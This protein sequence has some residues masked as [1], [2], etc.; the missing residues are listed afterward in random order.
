MSES[1]PDPSK[2]AKVR[3][4][5]E[6]ESRITAALA[7]VF[8]NIPRENFVQQRWFKAR[9]GHDPHNVDTAALWEKS[10]RADIIIFYQDRAL[11]VLELKREDLE[12]TQDDYEQAQSYA[13]QLTP[14]PPL[15]IVSNGRQTRVYDSNTGKEWSDDG[16]A[17]GSISRLVANAAKLAAS[18]MRWTIEALMGRELGVWDKAIRKTTERHIAALTNDRGAS[19]KPFAKHLLFPRIATVGLLQ[20]LKDG[21]R[22]VVVHGDPLTGKSNVLRELAT[23]TRGSDEFAVLL[24]RGWGVG[25]FQGLANLFAAELEWNISPND[26]RQWLRRMSHGSCGPSLVLAIDG[27]SPNSVLA[28]DLEELAVSPMGDMVRVV[29]TTD[30]ARSLLY[31]PDGR[32]MTAVGDAAA[33][34]KVEPLSYAE[35]EGARVVLGHERLAFEAGAEHMEDYRAPWVLR[36]LYDDAWRSKE[37]RDPKVTMRLPPA[38]GFQLVNIARRAHAQDA[39]LLRG[40]RLLARSYLHDEHETPVLAL[41]RAHGFLVRQDALSDPARDSLS[42][43]RSS[44]VAR[45]LRHTSGDDIVVPTIPEAFMME[46]AEAAAEQLAAQVEDDPFEAGVWLGR[47]MSATYLGDM[48]GAEAL[49]VLGMKRAGLSS[50]LITGLASIEPVEE[51]LEG[52][53]IEVQAEGGK[54]I[55]FKI[56]D[57]KIWDCDAEGNVRGEPT[58]LDDDTYMH[59]NVTPWMIL[60]QFARVATALVGD[61]QARLDAATLLHIGQCRFPLLRVTREQVGHFVHDLGEHG[62]VLCSEQGAIEPITQ[63]MAQMLSRPWPQAQ[64]W[65]N[66]CIATGAVP[67]LSRLSIALGEV[68][69]REIVSISDWAGEAT[70]DVV[71]ALKA[72]LAPPDQ[73]QA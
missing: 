25:L 29:I 43:L 6:L 32:N 69:G 62:R 17:A 33:T 55:F 9:L 47:R 1:T 60:G 20:A 24:A 71:A 37:F 70:K 10:G 19:G 48:V 58:E 3:P 42:G 5:A 63:A 67:L 72:A 26:A 54:R 15:L 28:A 52:G 27:V 73:A 11:A 14:R 45:V 23:R 21:Q 53:V 44:G 18:D 30:E 65:V 7:F 38:L 40:Y 57:G 13:N 2:E 12:L 41:A 39:D 64:D 49:R 34:V 61:D 8:P 22:F 68:R 66:A 59:A 16:D 31:R 35:F 36:T 51:R 56:D 50:A 4:E 46:L